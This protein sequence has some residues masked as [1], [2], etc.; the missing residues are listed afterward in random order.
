M[1]VTVDTRA[2]VGIRR[3]TLQLAS[4]QRSANRYTQ[5]LSFDSVWELME[6][7]PYVV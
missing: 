3:L 7:K 4:L 6:R 1:I 2:A 5:L